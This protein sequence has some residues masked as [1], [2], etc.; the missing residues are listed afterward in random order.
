MLSFFRKLWAIFK[1]WKSQSYNEVMDLV[2]P[3]VFENKAVGPFL[4][5]NK[6]IIGFVLQF[7]ALGIELGQEMFGANP[8]LALALT[9]IGLVLQ[10]LG[11]AHRGVK[12]RRK[13]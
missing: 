5:K 3:L 11:I 4:E 2:L 8:V 13:G 1:A 10:A 12:E 9:A 6:I 7:A